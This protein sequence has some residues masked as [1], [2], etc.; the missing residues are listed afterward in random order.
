MT[1]KMIALDTNILVR[2]FVNDPDSPTQNDLA[3]KLV[4]Q[5]ELIYVSQIVQ[6]ELVWVLN[7]RMNFDKNDI[8]KVLET[9]YQHNA[10]ILEYPERFINALT[11]YKNN[12]ADFSDYLIFGYA[13]ENNC[14]FWSFDKKL[15]KTQGVHILSETSLIALN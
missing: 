6:V 11:L 3:R 7:R 9:I 8:I 14:P 10:I 5:Y 2:V 4:N 12:Q 13:N 15:A 1:N